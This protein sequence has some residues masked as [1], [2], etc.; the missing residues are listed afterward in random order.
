[1]RYLKMCA[2]VFLYMAVDFVIQNYMAIVYALIYM[3]KLVLGGSS[4][5]SAST[6]DL[7]STLYQGTVLTSIISVFLLVPIYWFVLRL[8]KIKLTEFSGFH[9]ISVKT[10]VLAAAIGTALIIPVNFVMSYFSLDQLSPETERIFDVIFKGNSLPMLLLGIGI[11][12]P[13]MEELIFRGLVFN[14]LRR[15]IPVA[16]AVVLQGILFGAMHM[17]ISQFLYA[18]PLGILF[19]CIYVWTGSIL[20]TMLVHMFFNGMGIILGEI[21]SDQ[22]LTAALPAALCLAAAVALA[23][24]IYRGR[25][26]KQTAVV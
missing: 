7:E 24:L 26:Q 8:R 16:A 1:M 6:R 25:K 12:G 4:L 5:E 9:R 18:A 23:I 13:I 22:V 20:S 10:A 21:I 17:N 11:V 19:G 15:N 14:E 2:F 3:V